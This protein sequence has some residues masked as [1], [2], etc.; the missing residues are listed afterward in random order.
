MKITQSDL[1]AIAMES[2][3][4]YLL[5]E[6]LCKELGQPFPPQNDFQK[7]KPAPVTQA[8]TRSIPNGIHCN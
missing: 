4:A 5:M 8:I 7:G 1:Y 3:T 6:Q 2:D